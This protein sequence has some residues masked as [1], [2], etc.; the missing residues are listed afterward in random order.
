MLFFLV[1]VLFFC[2]FEGARVFCFYGLDWGCR[3]R[4]V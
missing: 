1:V 3:D 2:F 4:V